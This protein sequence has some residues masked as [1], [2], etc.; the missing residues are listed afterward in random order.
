MRSEGRNLDL[1][2]DSPRKMLDR[3]IM[4]LE[5]AKVDPNF[6]G[7]VRQDRVNFY[8]AEVDKWREMVG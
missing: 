5:T 2:K 1:Y 7:E 8:Q 4:Q 3:A 6:W